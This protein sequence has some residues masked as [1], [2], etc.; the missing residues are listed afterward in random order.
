MPSDIL[1]ADA[2]LFDLDGTLI[3]TTS[4][5]E[6]AWAQFA[7][8]YN[9]DL[10]ES[11]KNSHGVRYIERLR[12]WCGITD[13]DILQAELRRYEDL[14]VKI[15]KEQKERGEGG[16]VLTPG[17]QRILSKLQSSGH[18]NWAIVTSCTR[19]LVEQA[20]PAAGISPPPKLITADDVVNGKPDP[21]PYLTG[22][23]SLG[24]DIKRCVI[25]EDAP[26]G[27]KSGL[28]SS[29]TVLAVCTSHALKDIRQAGPDHVV[30]SFEHVDVTVLEDGEIELSIDVVED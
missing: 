7:S 3:E 26:A 27:I 22:A 15:A 25:F 17:A 23:A 1:K 18:A 16:F 2:I 6:I 8:E 13:P 20:L 14:E 19:Y 28:S 10:Q 21:E 24:V 9:F 12:V 5:G 4:A 29:A 11:L 30:K